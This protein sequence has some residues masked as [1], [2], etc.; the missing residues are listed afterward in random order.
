VGRIS[1]IVR[2]NAGIFQKYRS[3][4]IVDFEILEE[5]FVISE[6][7]LKELPGAS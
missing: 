4:H 2:L 5:V 6:P 1:E 3:P 7:V